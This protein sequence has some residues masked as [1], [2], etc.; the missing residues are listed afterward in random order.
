M[1]YGFQTSSE[2]AG[3]AALLVYGMYR[4][5]DVKRFKVTPDM[6]GIIERATRASAKR[7]MDLHDFIEKLKP[8]LCCAELKPRWMKLPDE[9]ITMRRDPATGEL[10]QVADQGRRQFWV[11]I[12]E[13]VDHGPV[14]D[15]LYRKTSLVT[16]LVRDRL[17]RERPL[18]QAGALRPEEEDGNDGYGS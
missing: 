16:A 8:R 4:S 2:P 3:L 15:V 1:F 18:E 6:W 10:M 11:E 17:E 7:A 14:L 5:R 13:E 12:F 9:T